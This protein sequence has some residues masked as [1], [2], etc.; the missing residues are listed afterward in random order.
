MVSSS[1]RSTSLETIASVGTFIPSASHVYVVR[2]IDSNLLLSDS[3]IFMLNSMLCEKGMT[4]SFVCYA[5]HHWLSSRRGVWL[6]GDDVNLLS[7]V[8][9]L[10]ANQMP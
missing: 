9:T 6:A 1:G 4:S 10:P 5:A 8:V 7:Y 2:S 3:H